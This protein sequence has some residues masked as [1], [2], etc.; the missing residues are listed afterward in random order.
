MYLAGDQWQGRLFTGSSTRRSG[1]LD[2]PT[3]HVWRHDGG[4]GAHQ[5]GGFGRCRIS[6]RTAF[7]S[8]FIFGLTDT[9]NTLSAIRHRPFNLYFVYTQ[10]LPSLV[11]KQATPPGETK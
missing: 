1:F 3:S 8:F 9:N 2:R 10:H 6:F 7:M 5:Q 11:K 4:P